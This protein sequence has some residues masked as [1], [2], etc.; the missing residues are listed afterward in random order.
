M[1]RRKRAAVV[2]LV[3]IGWISDILAMVTAAAIAW[4]II[5]G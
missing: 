3:V 2:A 5:G 1:M 4:L